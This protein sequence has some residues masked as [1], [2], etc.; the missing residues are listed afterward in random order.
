M[1]KAT[2]NRRLQ[3][4]Q[5]EQKTEVKPSEEETKNSEFRN[6]TMKSYALI[7]EM[8]EKLPFIQDENEKQR[9]QNEYEHRIHE[10]DKMLAKL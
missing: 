10:I 4:Q 1:I 7:G 5:K 2:Q 9:K 8:H 6:L 3:Q